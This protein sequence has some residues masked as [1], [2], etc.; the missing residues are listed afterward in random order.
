[1]SAI[2][3]GGQFAKECCEVSFCQ[4]LRE[5]VFTVGVMLRPEVRLFWPV[6]PF[7]ETHMNSMSIAWDFMAAENK[8]S[9]MSAVKDLLR[10][11]KRSTGAMSRSSVTLFMGC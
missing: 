4:E 7:S 9:G 1:M 2:S 6:G 11:W 10:P 3:R 8:T 5:D